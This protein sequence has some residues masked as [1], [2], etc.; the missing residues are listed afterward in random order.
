MAIL[1]RMTTPATEPQ[2]RTVPAGEFKTNCLRLMDEVHETGAPIVVTKHRR[3]VVRV[4]PF[5]QERLKL[6]GSCRAN[7]ASW[8]T[9]TASRPSRPM[10]GTC[11]PIAD[12]SRTA[13][14]DQQPQPVSLLLD[15][16][17]LLRL[18]VDSEE[19]SGSFKDEV[20]SD[21]GRGGVAVSAMTFVETTRL[22]HH[23]RI[24]LGCH[25]ALW[26]RERLRSGLREIAVSGEI[27]VESVLLMNSWVSQRPCRSDHRRHGHVG[28][29][30]T[31]YDGSPD[32]R[33]GSAEPD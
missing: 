25:P 4:S 21:L 29:D 1:V 2:E 16:N 33:L 19:I 12:A 30:A 7:C 22:H 28:W 11:S 24:D 18:A 23:G 13:T 15:T 32:H 17:V 31:G 3:P 6:V 14:S 20:E 26:R 8:A 9:S 10:T 27:A 5:R